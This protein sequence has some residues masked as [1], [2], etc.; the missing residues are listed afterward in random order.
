MRK[1]IGDVEEIIMKKPGSHVI[2]KNEVTW[3]M[4]IEENGKIIFNTKENPNLT[5]D[6]F[7]GKVLDI[8]ADHTWTRR[9]MRLK[10]T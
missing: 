5:A 3:F 7:A 10:V 1:L 2:F 4:K 9:F 6:E 8:L